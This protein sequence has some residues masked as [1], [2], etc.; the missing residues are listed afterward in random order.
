[1][2]LLYV[3]TSPHHHPFPRHFLHPLTVIVAINSSLRVL[4]PTTNLHTALT[5]ILV[6]LTSL[7]RSNFLKPTATCLTTG[8]CSPKFATNHDTMNNKRLTML[9]L[10]R[11]THSPTLVLLPRSLILPSSPF[12]P[13]PSPHHLSAPQLTHIVGCSDQPLPPLLLQSS[14]S[15]QTS[16]TPSPDPRR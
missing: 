12:S 16:T 9:S 13:F 14:N 4:L 10:T 7:I 15:H 3:L 1:M 6:L 8:R 5:K 2:A 11:S